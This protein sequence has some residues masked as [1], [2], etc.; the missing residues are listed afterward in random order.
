MTRFSADDLRLAWR[1]LFAL[2]GSFGQ[3]LPLASAALADQQ[4]IE[5]TLLQPILDK[6]VQTRLV[7]QAPDKRYELAHD[8]IAQT[9]R[10]RISPE[11]QLIKQ[12]RELLQR[13]VDNWRTNYLLI[14]SESLQLLYQHRA[15]L[16]TLDVDARTCLILSATSNDVASDTWH[17]LLD[18]P[19][20]KAIEALLSY[21]K[22]AIQIYAVRAVGSLKLLHLLPKLEDLLTETADK[23]LAAEIT[24]ALR[25]FDE[26]GLDIL[27]HVFEQAISAQV[28]TAIINDLIR[29]PHQ[30]CTVMLIRAFKNEIDIDRKILLINALKS[31]NDLRAIPV[32]V[33]DLLKDRQINLKER[34]I[35]AIKSIQDNTRDERELH[36]QG[37]L[38]IQKKSIRHLY[39]QRSVYGVLYVPTYLMHSIENTE[40][41]I[42]ITN[43]ELDD[44]YGPKRLLFDSEI[45]IALMAKIGYEDVN[46]IVPRKEVSEI[47]D[48]IKLMIS[49]SEDSILLRA[50]F[51][52]L[53]IIYNR[54][55]IMKEMKNINRN[56]RDILV[57]QKS[58]FGLDVPVHINNQIESIENE[59]SKIE[60]EINLFGIEE[61]SERELVENILILMQ[62]TSDFNMR[63]IAGDVLRKIGI[64]TLNPFINL[65][66]SFNKDFQDNIGRMPIYVINELKEKWFSRDFSGTLDEILY[67]FEDIIDI[68]VKDMQNLKNNMNNL[69]KTRDT[70]KNNIDIITK[71][72]QKYAEYAPDH[73]SYQLSLYKSLLLKIDNIIPS[74]IY[75]YD[76][77][78]QQIFLLEEIYDTNIS[79]LVRKSLILAL[80]KF[81][82]IDS[83]DIN[84]LFYKKL[85]EVMDILIDCIVNDDKRRNAAVYSISN[86]INH[87]D[88]LNV[89]KNRYLFELRSFLTECRIDQ[90]T[91]L[92]NIN[93]YWI[94]FFSS[95]IGS[96]GL[97]H[98]KDEFIKLYEYLQVLTFDVLIDKLIN[99]DNLIDESIIFKSLC[100]LKPFGGKIEE[101]IRYLEEDFH[102]NN[103][104]IIFI[105][106]QIMDMDIS[107]DVQDIQDVSS[108]AFLSGREFSFNNEQVSRNFITIEQKIGILQKEL[109]EYESSLSK[110]G[111]LY[112]PTY[113]ILKIEDIKEEIQ[114]LLTSLEKGEYLYEPDKGEDSEDISGKIINTYRRHLYHLE[115]QHAGFGPLDVPSYIVIEINNLK[116]K[117]QHLMEE[118]KTE[119]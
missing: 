39:A 63:Q 19:S 94:E 45:Y 117:I 22:V 53:R 54:I 51:D 46:K 91:H 64:A 18:D 86:L 47:V 61:F 58:K 108:N 57:L 50:C 89:L 99:V 107:I 101:Y 93:T 102:E 66:R 12:I 115:L 74:V 13:S 20:L 59:I 95:M 26:Q 44:L 113:I 6:L 79:Y 9:L 85:N 15:Y 78:R 96:I 27:I 25:R 90:S 114:K 33:Y 71:Q 11:E 31:G 82:K 3:R 60:N 34:L 92:K 36:L 116:A 40:K 35:S 81:N 24:S 23:A 97:T 109:H 118:T 84:Y 112:A 68:I 69:R 73:L 56:S 17:D 72:L 29:D 48:I 21:E 41:D 87:F 8:V 80:S 4:Q 65:L 49:E 55:E 119:S 42:E 77:L 103:K 30:H 88:V 62:K 70:Y 76:K 10:E 67:I 37:I 83:I 106:N 32:L 16:P 111:P 43:Q 75:E 38:N 7:K 104:L 98:K 110:F 105:Y 14:P 2:V 5:H 100:K 28:W 52:D 1:I